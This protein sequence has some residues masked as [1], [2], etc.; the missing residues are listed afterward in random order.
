MAPTT[1]GVPATGPGPKA[2][3]SM[4][5]PPHT[6]RSTAANMASGN[7]AGSRTHIFMDTPHGTVTAPFTV[8]RAAAR[9]LK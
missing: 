9:F 8:L 6:A 2:L 7:A 1:D 3:S 5:C 4:R